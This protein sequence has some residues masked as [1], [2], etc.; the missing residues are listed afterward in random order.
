MKA[1]ATPELSKSWWSKNKSKRLKSTGL[2][3]VLG[4]YEAERKKWTKAVASG[5]HAFQIEP[6]HEAMTA[7]LS[8]D[9][10]KAVAKAIAACDPKKQKET[11]DALKKYDSVFRKELA[12][13]KKEFADR[14]KMLKTARANLRSRADKLKADLAK[15]GEDAKKIEQT[16]DKAEAALDK[17]VN[18]ILH[19]QAGGK[20]DA[21]KALAKQADDEVGK[22]EALVVQVGRI[23]DEA[24]KAVMGWPYE[25]G[26]LFEPSADPY[27][28]F[29]DDLNISVQGIGSV[30]STVEYALEQA[31]VAQQEIYRIL[32]GAADTT[33][34]HTEAFRKALIRAQKA[35]T[36][37]EVN[38]KRSRAIIAKASGDIQA[39]RSISDPAELRKALKQLA[40]TLTLVSKG[41][42]TGKRRIE[43]GR[44]ALLRD[45]KGFPVAMQKDPQFADLRD[46][47]RN[48]MDIMDD[49][50]KAFTAEGNKLRTLA[51]DL[52]AAATA[53]ASAG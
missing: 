9:L 28:K 40:N 10:P 3:Q 19:E 46:Q 1:G 23:H 7:L 18:R 49:D 13:L 38:L 50:L 41:L 6:I 4:A 33:K 45:V 30:L 24:R 8:T 39:V 52:K 51:T 37:G 17:L 15:R 32:R 47:A 35:I 11:L 2:G 20:P 27:R 44:S 42:K 34:I 26:T 48:V 43:Q 14:E 16:A 21:A 25:P 5:A 22:I 53:S 29:A 36:D 12:A 31:N